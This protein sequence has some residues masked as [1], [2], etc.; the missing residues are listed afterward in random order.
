MGGMNASVHAMFLAPR[1]WMVVVLWW[2]SITDHSHS[3]MFSLAK[4]SLSHPEACREGLKAALWHS[5]W[6]CVRAF[7]WLLEIKINVK[8]SQVQSCLTLGGGDHLLFLAEGASFVWRCF[9]CHMASMTTCRDVWNSV[10]FPPSGTYL[11][12]RICMLSNF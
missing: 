3:V 6:F 12:I 11:F 2:F 10:N 5:L 9:H 1:L 4:I 7:L 8:V